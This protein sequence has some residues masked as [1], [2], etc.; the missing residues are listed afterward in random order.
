MTLLAYLAAVGL[1]TAADSRRPAI[2][3]EQAPTRYQYELRNRSELDLTATL[4]S[5]MVV[6]LPAGST[7]SRPAAELRRGGQVA[8]S[9]TVERWKNRQDQLLKELA[10]L[11]MALV[12]LAAREAVWHSP[13]GLAQRIEE[14][15]TG[16]RDELL[17]IK[18][19]LNLVDLMVSSAL[20]LPVCEYDVTFDG[21]Q[22]SLE[23]GDHC[24]MVRVALTPFLVKLLAKWAAHV[25]DPPD[26]DA[27]R[28]SLVAKVERLQAALVANDDALAASEGASNEWSPSFAPL[29]M[30]G[31]RRGKGEISPFASADIGFSAY[32]TPAGNDWE[33][34]GRLSFGGQLA[35][36]LSPELLLN[37]GAVGRGTPVTLR[38]MGTVGFERV[39]MRFDRDLGVEFD[40]T[41]LAVANLGY[42]FVP[43]GV[44]LR[45]YAP[46][47][48]PGVFV[49]AGI[50]HMFLIGSGWLGSA[51]TDE[52]EVKVRERGVARPTDNASVA[53]LYGQL[54][55]GSTIH[56]ALGSDVHNGGLVVWAG[57]RLFRQPDVT[58]SPEFTMTSDGAPATTPENGRWTAVLSVNVGFA[59]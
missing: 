36:A 19:G 25:V 28:S 29:P 10:E 24:D 16:F 32:K 59:F 27:S 23:W 50:G 3:L 22:F 2:A 31:F 41:T 33:R 17:K 52:T 13:A 12:E 26:F 35:F 43:V 55:V 15:K 37:R 54:R 57:A 49:D 7:R 42:E 48:G 4:P 8:V 58:P 38:P 46:T 30:D 20:G 14:A 53:N 34:G 21:E 5:G 9:Y 44:Q 18:A 11:E 39:N 40:G 56:S 6:D 47:P 51:G 45:M 1:A